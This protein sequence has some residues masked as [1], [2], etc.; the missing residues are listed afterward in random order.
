MRET[1]FRAWDGKRFYGFDN[2]QWTLSYNDISGWVVYLN[3]HPIGKQKAIEVQL[4]QYTGL[5]DRHGKEIY[6]GD[7]VWAGVYDS[8]TGN[9]SCWEIKP[10]DPLQY[11]FSPNGVS[12]TQYYLDDIEVI[13]N[14]YE[15]AEL[16]K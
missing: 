6:E 5:T 3:E 10:P 13:G 14:I 16:L 15:N 12:V 2:F 8:K 9:K 1:K 7:I 11:Y 4:Q